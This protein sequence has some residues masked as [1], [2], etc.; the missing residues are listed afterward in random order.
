MNNPRDAKCDILFF[1]PCKFSLRCWNVA[2]V[3]ID[4]RITYF[5]IY[6]TVLLVFAIKRRFPM[7]I[8]FSIWRR[9]FSLLSTANTQRLLTPNHP[10][11]PLS[12]GSFFLF[13]TYIS[14]FTLPCK[15]LLHLYSSF[16]NTTHKFCRF[17]KIIINMRAISLQQ[18]IFPLRLCHH[19]HTLTFFSL[20]KF[21]FS[22]QRVT[23][24]S[25]PRETDPLTSNLYIG[26]ATK[27]LR[28]LSLGGINKIRNHLVASPI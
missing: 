28:I 26:S 14:L 21:S 27:W 6:S 11:P 24:P 17:W 4:S 16:L 13:A 7:L 23:I 9:Y 1:L 20:P 2:S 18:R 22:L 19:R 12:L 15:R 3:T 25:K 8:Y 10:I 5:R